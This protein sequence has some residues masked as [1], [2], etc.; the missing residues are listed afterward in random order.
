MIREARN[1]RRRYSRHPFAGQPGATTGRRGPPHFGAVRARRRTR[2]PCGKRSPGSSPGGP[3]PVAGEDP[4]HPHRC[5]PRLS[6]PAHPAPPQARHQQE[7]TYV[8]GYPA[9]KAL[10]AVMAKVQT[11]CRQST[12]LPLD[13]LL[14]RLNRMLLGWTTYFKYGCSHATFSYLRSY[15]WKQVIRWQERRH[16][17]TVWKE[18]RRRYGR[19]PPTGAWNCSTRQGY[20]RNYYYYR[21]AQIS[22]PWPSTA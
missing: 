9:K 20:A 16:R 7:G 10:A 19:G 5:G 14:P 22:I 15:L 21:G 13:V 4:D 3:T 18:L 2:K 6:R 1:E 17:R 11:L 8:Y 12:N